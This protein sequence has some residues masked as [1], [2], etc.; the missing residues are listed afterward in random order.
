MLVSPRNAAAALAAVMAA[1]VAGAQQPVASAAA[2]AC[3]LDLNAPKELAVANFG[4]TRATSA[5]KPEDKTKIM[6][7]IVKSL[8]DK[9]DVYKANLA[10]RNYVLGKVLT[11]FAQQNAPTYVTTRGAVG[12]TTNPGGSVD[13]LMA[14]DTAYTAF[15][16][17]APQCRAEI[18]G[19][20][21]DDPWRGLANASLQA[22]SA[23]K[24][25]SAKVYATRSL[26]MNPTSPYAFHVLANVAHSQNDETT[27]VANWKR[28]VETSGTDSTYN[29]VRRAALYGIGSYSGTAAVKATGAERAALVSQGTQAY[30]A[31]L[32]EAGNTP[33]G[34][35]VQ[36][37]LAELLTLS[38]DSA[39]IANVYADQLA[40]PDKYDDLALA[41]AGVI[42]SN[43]KRPQ[44]ATKLFEAS[45]KANPYQRDAM[46]NV[47]SL[48]YDQG[49]YSDM[50]PLLTR[51]QAIDPN[52]PDNALLAAYA[53]QGLNKNAKATAMKRM[54]TDSLLAYKT[55]N[56]KSPVAVHV[57][58]FTRGSSSTK[59][60]MTVENRG[61]VAKSYNF[62]VDL[63][64]K[65]GNVA[66]SKDQSVGPIG[67]KGKQTVTVEVPQGGLT[68]VRYTPLS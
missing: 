62:K 3:N 63:L 60:T 30:R 21:M 61:T 68:G 33:D 40:N 11:M 9:P 67:P 15:A 16:A 59:V 66:V 26:A 4:V 17:A 8:T 50:L 27:A 51:L 38:G 18:A 49:R 45:L 31:F 5:A 53:F 56:E 14:I 2:S 24:Y 20:R 47:A 10:G 25:D 55:K 52:N 36:T 54:Y 39:S 1:G 43:A 35:L 42:A 19:L 12:Y 64:D 28:V 29:D 7:D 57:T 34:P 22:L 58:N 46:Y 44:D 65:A 37:R 41:Q 13:L 6:K 23:Q 48:Y 32:A